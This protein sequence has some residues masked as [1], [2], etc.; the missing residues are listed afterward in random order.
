M[1]KKVVDYIDTREANAVYFNFK[2]AKTV[3]DTVRREAKFERAIKTFGNRLALSVDELNNVLKR[4]YRVPLKEDEIPVSLDD[5][6]DSNDL[7]RKF[8][9]ISASDYISRSKHIPQEVT[10]R[11][12]DMYG[13]EKNYMDTHF[14]SAEEQKLKTICTLGFAEKAEE[15]FTKGA[16]LKTDPLI[17]I[18]KYREK[19]DFDG[20]YYF[21]YGYFYPFEL[22]VIEKIEKW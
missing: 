9:I 15:D 10:I 6:Y 8:M 7:K 20:L 18:K 1:K 16:L 17:E 11:F 14:V 21:I 13:V 12:Y 19:N 3:T 5:Y 2:N 4:N 22:S